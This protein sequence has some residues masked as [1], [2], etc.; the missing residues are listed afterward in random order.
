MEIISMIMSG[1]ALWAAGVALAVT[2][3][4]K[5]RSEK[6]RADHLKESAKAYEE[7]LKYRSG[8]AE[9]RFQLS[10]RIGKLEKGIVPD[11]EEAKKAVDSVNSFNRGLN[12][13]LNYDPYDALAKQRE[14]TAE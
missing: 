14:R 12:N 13:I 1:L 11:F 6:Q 4:E 10:E 5:K 9:E 8:T 2:V 3:Q 7:E